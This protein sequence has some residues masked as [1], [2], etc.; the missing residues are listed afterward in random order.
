M[1][2]DPSKIRYT[3]HEI[4]FEWSEEPSPHGDSD[5]NRAM[6]K[7]N[8][9]P[10]KIKYVDHDITFEW[11]DEPSPGQNARNG[12]NGQKEKIGQPVR[13]KDDTQAQ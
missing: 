3:N 8:I 9:D 11:S 1:K 12:S 2:I 7:E 10:S 6:K 13:R 5:R 4:T